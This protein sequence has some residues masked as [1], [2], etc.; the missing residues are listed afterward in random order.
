MGIASFL[1]RSS[2]ATILTAPVIYSLIIPFLMID[3]W[4]TV[5]QSIC[6]RAYGIPRVQRGQYIHFDRRK[7]HYLNWIEA[8]NCTFCSYANGV[9]AY[10]REVASRTEKYWCPIKHA[11]RVADP[12][13]R[14]HDFLEY[15]DA[16]GYRSRLTSLRQALRDENGQNAAAVD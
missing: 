1:A 13:E 14:Y 16:A 6:F 10:V 11:L 7:L 12:H 5:Y 4:T 2:L 15:G 8:L 3:L 9:I